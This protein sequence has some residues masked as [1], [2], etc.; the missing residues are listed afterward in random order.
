MPH[1]VLP[2]RPL[3]AA[4]ITAAL[5]IAGLAATAGASVQKVGPPAV[6]DALGD[7][8]TRGYDSQGSG[9]GAFADCPAFSWATGSNASVN[10]YF[11]RVKALNPGVV[12][13]RPQTSQTVGGNDAVTGATM[14]NLVA[15]ATNAVNAT[16]K[17]DQVLI[18]LGANDVCKSSEAAMTPVATFR[19]QYVAGLNVLSAGLPD[20]RINVSSIPNIFQLWN[21]LKGNFL[22]TSTWSIAG[23]CQSML[24][25]PTSN[26]AANVQRRANVQQ[27]NIDYNA[28]L[29][30]ECAKFIHC[31]YDGGAA[32]AIN[33]LA[34][35]VSTLD[36]FHPN[37]NGQAKAAATAWTAGPN[38]ADVTAPTTTITRDHAAA[39]VDDWYKEN[40]GITL[41]SAAADL[42]GTEYFYKL[43]G[44]AD[45][46]WT[47]YTAPFTITSEGQTTVTA[48]S[49]DQ[50][51][52]IE[53]SKSDVIKIDKTAPTFALTCPSGPVVL[54]TTDSY[55]VSSAAD[56]RSG[57]ATDPNGSTTFTA[58]A[59]GPQAA[60]VSIADKAGNS[61]SHGC[62]IDVAY[63]VPGAPALSAGSTP[64][65]N[66]TFTLA[67]NGADP[68][69]FAIRYQ[70]QHRDADDGSFSD[71]ATGL[72]ALSYGLISEAEGTWRYRVKGADSGLGLETAFSAESS[73]VKVDT[74][75]PAA[76]TATADRTPDYAGGG[77]WFKDSVQV[78][79]TDNGDPAL[80]DGSAGS[81][82][83]LAT[84]TAPTTKSTSGAHTPTGTVKDNVG[85]ESAAGS[86][87]VQVDATAPSVSVTCPANVLLHGTAAALITAS[88]AESGL[89][90]DPS[91]SPPIDTTTVG[92]RISSG[93]AVDNVDHMT[94][95]T[96]STAVQYAFGGVQQPINADDSS[97]FKLGS[98]V[99][100]K[101]ALADAAGAPVPTGAATLDVAKLSNAIEGTF[102]EA[103]TS[104]SANAGNTFRADATGGYIYNL[105]T[106]P[107][108]A[109]TWSLRIT[110]D[111]GTT[112]RRHISLK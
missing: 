27:R 103:A 87:G 3:A 45:A 22:A 82:V 6:I 55:S 63:P 28:V 40:V 80:Q 101:F 104:G 100:V 71:V 35:D 23:I 96:C 33:F 92:T 47:K 5:G 18:L 84:L 73:T 70:L 99:P 107:L 68:S 38:F 25:S 76:P 10:S 11:N 109:G 95:K 58:S 59:P 110:L 34:S 94:G 111:D 78:A 62:T 17:P 49:V 29:R 50:N 21:V 88:D 46:P 51:G 15:Q 72:S 69:N 32:Y 48:R 19:S 12:L 60:S 20:A 77:G 108:S 13:A 7:S 42:A 8:I 66:G 26:T 56:D 98:T 2:R 102:V 90:T 86:T 30:D 105:G 4:V 64:N 106:K 1:L 97:I 89:A 9:C 75:A 39:G 81:G 52:N 41:S 14:S 53:A 43:D 112:Y 79:F 74:S 31:R 24:A 37:V 65:A 93:T 57:F 67:W 44:A 83:D 36:Y 61:V 85:N 54:G 91:G 16:N